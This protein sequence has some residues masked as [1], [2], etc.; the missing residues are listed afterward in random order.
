MCPLADLRN[1]CTI[2]P[3]GPNWDFKGEGGM[4]ITG[5]EW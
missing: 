2:A 4:K 1:L 5:V 3:S